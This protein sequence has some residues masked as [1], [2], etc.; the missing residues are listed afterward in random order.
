MLLTHVRR[1]HTRGV[2][3]Y[4]YINVL[5]LICR[6]KFIVRLVIQYYIDRFVFVTVLEVLRS[7]VADGRQ[8]HEEHLRTQLRKYYIYR[9]D[10]S[11]KFM[12]IRICTKLCPRFFFSFFVYKYDVYLYKCVYVCVYIYESLTRVFRIFPSFFYYRLCWKSSK[13]TSTRTVRT[14]TRHGILRKLF[15]TFA[16]NFY[17]I[18]LRVRKNR[19]CFKCG[20][21]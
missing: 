12:Y 4:I 1:I 3:I 16:N 8:K 14:T 13:I 10:A 11:H 17:E 6:Y 9:T 15:R 19:F 5:F 7:I 21:K 20:T 18:S 2:Y